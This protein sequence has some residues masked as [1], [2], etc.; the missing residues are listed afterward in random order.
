MDLPVQE[1]IGLVSAILDSIAVHPETI[2]ITALQRLE[3]DRR[4]DAYLENPTD[5]TPWPE[6]KNKLLAR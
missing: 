4:M 2:E 1:H 3:L 5:G 6:V